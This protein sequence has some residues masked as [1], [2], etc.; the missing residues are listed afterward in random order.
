MRQS[1]YGQRRGEAP[2]TGNLDS[3]RGASAR[4]ERRSDLELARTKS[5]QKKQ[6]ERRRNTGRTRRY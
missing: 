4:G 6:R 2:G 3:S 1:Y 5:A